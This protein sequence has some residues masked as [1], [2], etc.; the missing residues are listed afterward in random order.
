[1]SPPAETP[2][3]E[4]ITFDGHTPAPEPAGNRAVK[5]WKKVG[6]SFGTDSEG[7]GLSVLNFDET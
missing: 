4:L 5:A 1:M 7:I 2:V 6:E 3:G